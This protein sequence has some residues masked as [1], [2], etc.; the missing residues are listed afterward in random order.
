MHRRKYRYGGINYFYG[1]NKT[2]HDFATHLFCTLAIPFAYILLN[3]LQ[4][5]LK[6][7]LFTQFEND[8]MSVST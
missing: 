4:M 8:S 1:K 3:T 7:K 6:Q 5:E 2:I